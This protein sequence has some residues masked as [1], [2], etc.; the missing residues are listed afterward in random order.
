MAKALGGKA[1][2]SIEELVL[3]QS[4]EMAALVHVLE[5]RGLL[6]QAEVLAEIK[7]LRARV[8]NAH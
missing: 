6:T 2:V 4:Y 5:R 3:A 8:A 1:A 7:R